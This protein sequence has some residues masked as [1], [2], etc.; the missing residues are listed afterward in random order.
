MSSFKAVH[1]LSSCRNKISS[2]FR[3][4]FLHPIKG[5]IPR[6]KKRFKLTVSGELDTHQV[7]D[8]IEISSFLIKSEVFIDENEISGDP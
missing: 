8:V 4:L 6:N 5:G 1:F 2:L 7:R 3:W